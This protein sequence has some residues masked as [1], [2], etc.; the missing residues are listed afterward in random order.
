LATI[1]GLSAPIE[2]VVG[3]VTTLQSLPDQNSAFKLPGYVDDIFHISYIP[4]MEWDVEYTD[5]LES[6]WMG[7]TEAEQED[8]SATI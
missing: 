1:T 7:L 5:E 8:V 6:W 4:Y 2:L 3:G